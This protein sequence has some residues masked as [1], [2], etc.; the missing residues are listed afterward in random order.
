MTR[1]FPKPREALT[2]LLST[3]KESSLLRNSGFI[4]AATIGNAALGFIFWTVIAHVSHPYEVGL[5]SSL[6]AG[7]TLVSLF[8][9]IGIAQ[10][11]IQ[12]LPNLADDEAWSAFATVGVVLSG[13]FAT[14]VGMGVALILPLLSPN[15]AE[16]RQPEMLVPFALGAGLSTAAIATDAIY[17]SSRRSD[18]MLWRNAFFGVFKLLILV[19]G[20]AFVR[21]LSS[22]VIV[23][24]WV[25]GLAASL[26]FGTWVLLPRV[27]PEFHLSFQG[28]ARSVLRWW[29]PLV[30]HHLANVGG[31]LVPFILPVLVVIRLSARENAFSYLTWSVGAIFFLVSPAVATSLFAEGSHGEDIQGNVKRSI[32]FIAI[33]LTPAI[34]VTVL[35]SSQILLLFGRQYAEN[36]AT[37]LVLLAFSAIPDAITNIAVSVLRVRQELHLAVILNIS[38]AA[39]AIGL[40]WVLLPHF[41]IIAPGIAWIT[42]QTAG[43]VAVGVEML[44]NRRGG[45]RVAELTT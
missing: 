41:G 30:G 7:F 29:R 16:L 28:G 21:W 15:F 38:M 31:T 44:R 17:V 10:L 24:S 11:L 26:V 4:M 40:S 43:S 5:A 12:V 14:C 42:A 36:G 2:R 22:G 20:V 9:N 32:L 19:A 6:I 33:I 27:R 34:G 18:Q 37:L 13:A 23:A 45:G 3:W 25:V 8:A 1:R 39:I 35:F